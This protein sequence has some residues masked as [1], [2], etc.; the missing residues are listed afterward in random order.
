MYCEIIRH[1]VADL[2]AHRLSMYGLCLLCPN[3][4]TQRTDSGRS[5]HTVDS[6]HISDLRLAMESVSEHYEKSHCGSSPK[7]KVECTDLIIVCLGF[8]SQ[9]HITPYI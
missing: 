6:T 1:L 5:A 2:A 7:T 8:A 9:E 3:K 4:R